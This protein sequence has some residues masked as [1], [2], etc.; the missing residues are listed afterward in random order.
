MDDKLFQLSLSWSTTITFQAPRPPQTIPPPKGSRQPRWT[1][2]ISG[3]T[4]IWGGGKD[5]VG[6]FL[7]FFPVPKVSSLKL[8]RRHC[9]QQQAVLEIQHT[10]VKQQ[11]CFTA[12]A[13]GSLLEMHQCP[14][15]TARSSWLYQKKYHFQRWPG[16]AWWK[17]FRQK[18]LASQPILRWGQ[19]L[20]Y[21]VMGLLGLL[22]ELDDVLASLTAQPLWA[23]ALAR[24]PAA[25]EIASRFHLV[26][27]CHGFRR[28][29]WVPLLP[30]T[31]PF[32][33]LP[34]SCRRPS[35]CLGTIGK[36]RTLSRGGP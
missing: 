11:T 28:F 3:W 36:I 19:T 20:L 12:C 2:Y 10:L 13:A 18:A 33:A 9:W 32:A 14:N 29:L 35:E 22:F 7:R 8:E 25:V 16:V 17:H 31:S 34:S 21:P 24:R 26:S 27:C 30:W 23:E 1:W 5:L 4:E 15:K 6:L